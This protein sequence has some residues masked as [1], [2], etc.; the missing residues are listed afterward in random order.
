MLSRAKHNVVQ[1]GNGDSLACCVCSI[2]CLL[3]GGVLGLTDLSDVL[4]YGVN[5]V[6]GYVHNLAAL[7]ITK[8]V[9]QSFVIGGE[10]VNNTVEHSANYGDIV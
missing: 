5:A 7:V 9:C 6:V 8:V 3:E 2:D 4:G 1:Q 10:T